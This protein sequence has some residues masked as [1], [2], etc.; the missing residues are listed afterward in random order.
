M[1]STTGVGDIGRFHAILTA[2]AETLTR[3]AGRAGSL[4]HEKSWSIDDR[5]A[6]RAILEADGNFAFIRD[7]VLSL[8]LEQIAS[9][10]IDE[11]ARL[12]PA[13]RQD[14]STR[15]RRGALRR[16]RARARLIIDARRGSGPSFEDA[17]RKSGHR[18][19]VETR[20]A[21]IVRN[22]P[23]TLRR[24]DVHRRS[25][26]GK[27]D[28]PEARLW[29][30]A[31]RVAPSDA[32]IRREVAA[33]AR[34][35]LP[36][37]AGSA[38][39]CGTIPRC[40]ACLVGDGGLCETVLPRRNSGAGPAPDPEALRRER[41]RGECI[42][43]ESL[44]GVEVLESRWRE[45]K[46][47]EPPASW[48]ERSDWFRARMRPAMLELGA[49]LAEHERRLERGILAFER[50]HAA[51]SGSGQRWE[52]AWEVLSKIRRLESEQKSLL[53]RRGMPKRATGLGPAG[54]FGATPLA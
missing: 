48:R 41:L 8:S 30:F 32:A 50:V 51:E 52:A 42:L 28:G 15:R 7:D 16:L 18:E 24:I 36:F 10:S 46:A 38:A 3:C 53:A 26:D 25:L 40:D 14:D 5:V 34:E 11:L 45:L 44:D 17:V 22:D 49:K 12:V 35:L 47:Q 27:A 9:S 21:G 33:Q 6:L 43:R 1:K 2:V 20:L 23:D 29:R 54:Q 19:R 39:I 13:R 31:M 37:I 4:D